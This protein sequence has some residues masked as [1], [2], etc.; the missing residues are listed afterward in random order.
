MKKT[1]TL[2]VARVRGA[3]LAKLIILGSIVGCTLITTLFGVAALVGVEVIHFNNQYVTGAKGLVGAPFIGAFVGVGFGL[4]SFF[5]IYIGL[6]F[7]SFF[8]S[9]TLEYVPAT[10]NAKSTSDATSE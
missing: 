3:T 10:K 1:E 5:F 4:F 9:I 2:D 6:R 8:R 7:Y